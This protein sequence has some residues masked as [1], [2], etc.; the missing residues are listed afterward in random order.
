MPYSIMEALFDGRLLPWE[1]STRKT[2]D[3]KAIADEIESEKRHFFEKMSLDDCQRF[4]RLEDLYT[5]VSRTEDADIHSYGFMLGA[6]L[7]IEVFE[8]K[9][10]LLNG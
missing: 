4:Q 8:N 9:E 1:R 3:H 6:L 2:A 7:M 10:T 5:S